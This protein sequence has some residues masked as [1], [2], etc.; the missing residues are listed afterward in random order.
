MSSGTTRGHDA[1]RSIVEATR[2]GLYK[3]GDALREEEVAELEGI[4]ARFA[5]HHAT[6]A[7]IM[8]LRQLNHA[9]RNAGTAAAAYE[10]NRSFHTQLYDACRSRYL[11]QTVE[12]LQDTIAILPETTSRMVQWPSNWPWIIS[13]RR[14]PSALNSFVSRNKVI[15]T[16]GEPSDRHVLNCRKLANTYADAAESNC[17]GSGGRMI[18]PSA[19]ERGKTG[20]A[21]SP[22][23]RPDEN[24]QAGRIGGTGIH[25]CRFGRRSRTQL[26]QF[27]GPD[28]SL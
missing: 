5:A 1:Y 14:P 18:I 11:R 19:P 8:H 15:L 20:H 23:R 24:S 22:G 13:G 4:V 27:H 6:E 12:D 21:G 9:F 16:P 7:E 3:P 28:Q 10:H 2:R 17:F 25:G 26:R